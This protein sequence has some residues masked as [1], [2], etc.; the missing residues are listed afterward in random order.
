MKKESSREWCFHGGELK[1]MASPH[2]HLSSLQHLGL[3]RSSAETQEKMKL[4]D[5]LKRILVHSSS[6]II[7]FRSSKGKD[8]WQAITKSE[9]ESQGHW[10]RSFL[11]LQKRRSTLCRDTPAILAHPGHQ[12]LQAPAVPLKSQNWASAA[13][14]AESFSCS[15]WRDTP[16]SAAGCRVPR[17]KCLTPPGPGPRAQN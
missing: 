11:K 1:I 12:T 8:S 6:L 4:G 5:N 17:G 10:R 13:T 14:A 9:T 3:R 7:E 15:G 16:A 2:T